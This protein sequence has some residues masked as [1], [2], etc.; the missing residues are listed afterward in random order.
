MG[1]GKTY[2]GFNSNTAEKLLLD[3]GAFFKNFNVKTDDFD[4]AVSA[5]KLIGATR[6]GGQFEAKPSVRQIQVDGVKGAAKGLQVIDAWDVKMMANVLEIAPAS[7][8]LALAASEMDEDTYNEQGYA[9]IK[10][11]NYIE[12]EDYI[13]NITYVGKISGK[14]KPVIIQI[15]HALNVDGL[16]LSVK[17]K[18]EAV[19]ALNFSGSYDPT[20]LDNPPFAIFYPKE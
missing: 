8:K 11:K 7:L 6:G 15:Y 10:A 12:I 17:D 16:T 13:E 4:S 9:E 5:G 3:A 18:D 1:K 20:K 14:Q 2:S 19:I